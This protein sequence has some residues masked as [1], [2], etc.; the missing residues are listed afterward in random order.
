MPGDNNVVQQIVK[1]TFQQPRKLGEQ[2]TTQTLNHWVS[3]F[4]NYYARD[5][6][7]AHFLDPDT[8]WDPEEDTYNITAETDGRN[9]RA[10]PIGPLTFQRN[11]NITGTKILDYMAYIIMLLLKRKNGG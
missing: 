8:R 3:I 6:F 2:E 9:A 10:R 4:T 11:N 1:V 7:S 5:S